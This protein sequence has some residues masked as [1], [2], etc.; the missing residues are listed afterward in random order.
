MPDEPPT[1]NTLLPPRSLFQFSV[2]LREK[3][4]IWSLKSAKGVELGEEYALPDLAGLDR[5]TPA[6]ERRFA[7]VRMAWASEGLAVTIEVAGKSQELWCRE[8]R[9]DESDGLQLWIDTRATHNIHRASKFCTRLAFAPLG[10]GRG[11]EEPVA[12]Q[13][14]I[15]RA[16]ENARPVKPRELRVVSKRK[17]DGY[18]LA[19]FI[20]AVVL[21]G[22]D[23]EQYPTLGFNYA[24]VD[25]E[26]G[27]QTF[28]SGPTM[29]YDEDPSCWATLEMVSA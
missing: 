18:R 21:T 5:E 6:S 27:L 8:S 12:D 28:S 26:L 2:P 16:R 7:D 22:Y 10:G 4:P 25:R 17:K 15:N 29:P 1:I 13:L 19:A 14:L 20:P 23:P 11:N 24:L 3:K 9:L